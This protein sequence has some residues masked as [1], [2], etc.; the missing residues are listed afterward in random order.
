M[1][2]IRT[3]VYVTQTRA[4]ASLLAVYGIRKP[5]GYI[6]SSSE[7]VALADAIGTLHLIPFTLRLIPGWKP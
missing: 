1:P 3:Y 4:C 5:A 6:A 2:T 7:R